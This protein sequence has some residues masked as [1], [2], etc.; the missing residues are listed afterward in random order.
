MTL[1]FPVLILVIY[2][3]LIFQLLILVIYADF[4]E[5][6]TIKNSVTINSD[7]LILTSVVDSNYSDNAP[8]IDHHTR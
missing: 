4:L 2:T 5:A 6:V 3:I 7:S 1:I 8:N